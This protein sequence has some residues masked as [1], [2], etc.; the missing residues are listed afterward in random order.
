M[1]SQ[2]K[3]R[4]RDKLVTWDMTTLWCHQTKMAQSHDAHGMPCVSTALQ[5]IRFKPP[6]GILLFVRRVWSEQHGV[7]SDQ[8]VGWWERVKIIWEGLSKRLKIIAGYHLTLMKWWLYRSMEGAGNMTVLQSLLTESDQRRSE[9][10][11]C[12]KLLPHEQ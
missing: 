10:L 12:L 5:L 4:Q 6:C 8:T 1:A 11:S 2:S 3:E 9:D 7:F